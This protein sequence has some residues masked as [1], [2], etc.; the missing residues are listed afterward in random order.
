MA[1]FPDGRFQMG[2]EDAKLLAPRHL[3]KV[4]AFYLDTTE[5]TVGAYRKGEAA[6]PGEMAK[7]KVTDDH[8]I[9]SVSFDAATAYAESIGKRLPE[10]A[11]Y[12]IAA[13]NGGTSQ[14]PWGNTPPKADW[15]FGPVGQ[16]DW[17][18]TPTKPPVFGLYSN[19]A[20]WTA[21][22]IYPYPNSPEILCHLRRPPLPGGLPQ[23]AQ[24]PQRSQISGPARTL[25]RLK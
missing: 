14:Y 12:E 19:V 4:A 6:L 23:F 9:A 5:V 20:E 25:T 18:C 7:L 8:A 11:E 2:S 22:W 17:D 10:E 16:P 13:T 24:R 21:S 3:R 15:Q 1:H